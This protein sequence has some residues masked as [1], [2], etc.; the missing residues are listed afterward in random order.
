[1]KRRMTLAL[2]V[3]VLSLALASVTYAA[4]TTGGWSVTLAFFG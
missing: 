3:S 2:L 1:M 4:E